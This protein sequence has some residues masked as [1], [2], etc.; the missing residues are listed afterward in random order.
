M[1][2]GGAQDRADV[3]RLAGTRRAPR[4]GVAPRGERADDR[5]DVAGAL[6]QL[7]VDAR[8]HLA[9]PLAGQQAVG[10]HAVQPRAQLLGRDAGQ[11]ALELD[12]PARAGGEVA[13]D[14]QRPLVPD[15]IE[16][17]SVRRPLVVGMPL[18]GRDRRHL[19]ATIHRTTGPAGDFL[20]ACRTSTTGSSERLARIAA[21]IDGATVPVAVGD[22][23][24]LAEHRR[25]RRSG[26]GRGR[27]AARRTGHLL[28]DL[29][30][31]FTYL[32]AERVD[33]LFP[34]ARL[35]AG[36]R[37]GP[38]AR[39]RPTRERGRG[40]RAR[41]RAA[42]R[43]ARARP[44]D[45]CARRCASR[46]SPPSAAAPRRSSSPRRGWRSA[47]ASSS[48][49]PRCSPRRPPPRTSAS[50]TA[51]SAAGDAARDG[52]MEAGRAPAARAGRRPPA[53]G[54]RRARCCSRGE[55]R[56][57]EAVAAA[58]GARRAPRRLGALRTLRSG[59]CCERAAALSPT[60][61]SGRAIRG[62]RSSSLFALGLRR[63]PRRRRAAAPL[64]GHV[65]AASCCD[66]PRRVVVLV[67]RRERPRAAR[68]R[69]RLIRP[70]DAVAARRPHAGEPPS[71]RGARSRG[72]PRNFLVDAGAGR[73]CSE[74]RPDLALRDAGV[75]D[76]VL[77]RVPHRRRGRG[78]LPAPTACCCA[79]SGWS[80]SCARCSRTSR[81][82]CRPAPTSAARAS[83]CAGSCCSRCRRSTSS[84]ASSS[85]GSRPARD[86]QNLADLGW[87]VRD[88]GRRRV[89]DLVRADAAARAV[90][91]STR[92]TS[93]AR[94]PSASRRGERGARVPVLT[95]RRDR[96]R[97]RRRSTR[98][99]PGWRSA[100]GCARRSARSSTREVVER[101]L[102]EGTTDLE[103]EEVEVSVLFLDIR[104]FT[105]LAERLER[106]RGRRA[107]Q[108]VLRA[109]SCRCSSA[110]AGTRTSSSATG[111]SACSARPQRLP[112]H[113]DR[114]V[115]AALRHRAHASHE[116]YGGELRIGVGVNSGP[117]LA[118]TIGGGGHVEFTVIGDAVN[119]AARVEEV[120]R[121]DR[122]RRAASPRRRG[123]L[124]TLPFHGFEE[125]PDGRAEGQERAG[126]LYAPLG[127]R[128]SRSIP[129][130]GDRD[131]H[132][133]A[134][135]HGGRLV[136][137][138]LK[139]H[140]V[141]KLFTLSGGHLFSIYDGC[142]EEGIDIVD[143][144]H[145]QAAAFAAEGWAKVTREPG[146]VRADRGPGR[147]ERDERARRRRSRT[148]RR[149]SCS[150]GA[151]RRCAGG[152]ARC[153]RSTTCRS[154]GR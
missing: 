153:R 77:V 143:V 138:R 9:V 53:R 19:G 100:S 21:R 46:R 119:T 12:E 81:A 51:C 152:R 141:T 43:L 94:R 116:R 120:T 76:L 72:L 32:A 37:G 108:R 110:T 78:G 59:A 5:E 8:R 33:R 133:H 96:R 49:T 109:A 18:G 105:A 148:T 102:E 113:A 63:R 80:C 82:T 3:D 87:D 30:S 22:V 17:A 104:G 6:G 130:H 58:P 34:N 20:D 7:V 67:L 50:R 107:A 15:E 64:P 44:G 145:E 125:R 68:S 40:A 132:Q 103:G 2:D 146:V 95:D 83:R 154:C 128:G 118:G 90:D 75:L 97:S 139:A 47:A 70:A 60:A 112:D 65:D 1:P 55:D 99:S 45:A 137:K 86:D 26:A 144:R 114:A 127:R 129:A 56:L 111:C 28:F 54:A 11:H 101:V 62:R 25:T 10:D 13:D 14:E 74:R 52:A 4:P 24:S 29:S 151:R 42:A 73:S 91:R 48:T 79:S 36:P 150:A 92:S 106:A 147:D 93:C 84:P 121:A 41:A 23:I 124:L 57:G 38:P 89:H 115:L 136:A 122:R 149:C 27:R 35:A 85:P 16:R 126:A 135:L 117:V 71:P 88:R 131:R 123:A 39:R 140:G 142:R 134:Q 69:S 61:G 98:W 66:R 31:P